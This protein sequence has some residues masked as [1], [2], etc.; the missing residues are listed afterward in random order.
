MQIGK[1][2]TQKDD[3]L[4][5]ITPHDLY[6]QIKNPSE[7]N[8]K[9]LDRLRLVRTIDPKQYSLLKKKL[10][11]V[12]CGVFNPPFRRTENFGY[13]QYFMLDI[14]HISDKELSVEALKAKITADSRVLLCF[15]SP[16]EDGLKALFQLSEKCYD[17]GKYSLFYKLFA[18]AFAQ[19]YHIEQVVDKV[20]SDVTRACFLSHDEQAH[21]NPDAEKVDMTKFVD[22]D[23]VFQVKE[24]EKELT[25]HPPAPSRFDGTSSPKGEGEKDPDNDAFAFIKQQL[26]KKQNIEKKK[27]QIYVPEQLETIL[28]SLKNYIAEA[29]VVID[30]IVNINYGKKFKL[31]SGLSQAEINLFFGKKGFS[32]AKTPKQG[33]SPQLNDLM[34]A[35]IQAFINDYVMIPNLPVNQF[36]TGKD[37]QQQAPFSPETQENINFQTIQGQAKLLFMEKNYREAYNLYDSLWNGYCD[38]MSEW[39]CYYYAYSAQKSKDYDNALD[40]CRKT[41]R[42]FRNFKNIQ[43]VYAWTIYYSQIKQD[44]IKDETVFLKAAEGILKL[45]TQNDQF[46]PFVLTVMKVVDYFNSKQ[47][48]NYGKI[49][50]WTDKL[51]KNTLDGQSFTFTDHKGKEREIASKKE[52]YY[53]IRSKALLE[54]GDFDRCIALC[55]E[56]FTI[57]DFKRLHYGNNIWFKWRTALAYEGK[58]DLE[59]ALK[60]LHKLLTKKPEWFIQKQIAGIYLKQKK[61]K[62]SLKYALDSA[63]NNTFID[64]ILKKINLYYILVEVLNECGMT[65]EANMHLDFIKSIKDK[66]DNHRELDI[67]PE[68]IKLWKK[69]LTSNF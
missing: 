44:E 48:V 36:A 27:P 52:Q 63:L 37:E 25:P 59:K 45:C 40:V 1:N 42:K 32:V 18:K 22:F 19:Q 3:A 49:L 16:S 24:L 9:L 17:S 31:H 61:H 21:F 66:Y 11:Y 50:E 51:D 67:A 64:V 10:P 58:G 34:A 46:S 57:E 8:R 29:N 62:E 5:A 13:C 30:E 41:Y 12:V 33:M 23:N 26:F 53:M 35:Y 28:D 39:D 7:A 68:M 15:V 56:V 38:L 55:D 43:D 2:I 47:N 60:I 6:E 20:T 69:L 4:S 14:D 54:I 65:K